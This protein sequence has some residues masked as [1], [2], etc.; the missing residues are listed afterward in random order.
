MSKPHR[1]PRRTAKHRKL[2][3]PSR[4]RDRRGRFQ[5][6]RSR[7]DGKDEDLGY[8]AKRKVRKVKRG[9]GMRA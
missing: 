1:R 3:K 7:W 6:R 4:S 2:R 9:I 8:W 5:R